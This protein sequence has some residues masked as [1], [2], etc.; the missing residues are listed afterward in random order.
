MFGVGSEDVT[1]GLACS[2]AEDF[3][4]IDEERGSFVDCFPE[5]GI[6][7]D[8][9]ERDGHVQIG[10]A[11]E[12]CEELEYVVEG[13]FEAVFANGLEDVFE[14]L[15]EGVLVLGYFEDG[16]EDDVAVVAYGVEVSF[17]Y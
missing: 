14:G 8:C 16:V 6:G 1:L 13:L 4:D 2:M 10:D 17:E 9:E 15:V 7:G 12:E 3:Y 5:I 11:E